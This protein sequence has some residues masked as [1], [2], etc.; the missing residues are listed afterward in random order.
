MLVELVFASL[1]ATAIAVTYE[2]LRE[3]KE[4]PTPEA[5]DRVFA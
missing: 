5:L 4:G 2:Q 1:S 3:A